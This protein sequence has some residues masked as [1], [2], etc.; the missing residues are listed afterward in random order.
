MA[1]LDAI[2]KALADPIRLRIILLLLRRDLCVCELTSILGLEQSRVSHQL[3][4][5][6]AAGLAQDVR[7][8]KWI[9]Y[10][11]P[12]AVKRG[13]GPFLKGRGPVKAGGTDAAAR[14]L[15]RLGPCLL[16]S[17]RRKPRRGPARREAESDAGPRTRGPE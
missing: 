7:D 9:I 8:G 11:I 3:R 10:R 6:R 15:K 13:L 17:P 4:I 16:K 2:F 14:D 1:D 12:G 5:L